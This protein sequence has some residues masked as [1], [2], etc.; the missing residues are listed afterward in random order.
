MA[1]KQPRAHSRIIQKLMI[2][3]PLS[4]TDTAKVIDV[5]PC[6]SRRAGCDREVASWETSYSVTSTAFL[7]A[8]A[9]TDNHDEGGNWLEQNETPKVTNPTQASLLMHTLIQ[10]ALTVRAVSLRYTCTS[11]PWQR[12]FF[13]KSK[14]NSLTIRKDGKD[15]NHRRTP[16]IENTKKNK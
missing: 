16:N 8:A 6:R 7:E 11:G 13:L 14:T 3:Q 9:T 1:H 12:Q 2:S 15:A 10:Y 5:Q 4:Q